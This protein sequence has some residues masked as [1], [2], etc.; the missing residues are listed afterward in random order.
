MCPLFLCVNIRSHETKW[1]PPVSVQVQNHFHVDVTY[2]LS[3]IYFGTFCYTQIA[4]MVTK[5]LNLAVDGITLY[6][7]SPFL[8]RTWILHLF[9]W[10]GIVP[11]NA[12]QCLH[13]P[14]E[15]VL[16]STYPSKNGRVFHQNMTHL[17]VSSLFPYFACSFEL[18]RDNLTTM[19]GKR[20]DSISSCT[21]EID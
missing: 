12:I 16:F 9:V 5:S 21:L 2:H 6:V 18:T 1:W 10:Q 7:N 19:T 15:N 11:K 3:K 14:Y 4:K 17:V 20:T 8:N 13:R